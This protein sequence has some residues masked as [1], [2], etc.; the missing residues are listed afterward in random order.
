MTY[1]VVWQHEA[2]TE[3]RRLRQLD[4]AGAKDCAAAIRALADNPRPA[5]ARPLGG[6]GYWRLSSGDW[7]ILYR[8]DDD[9][10]TVLV[11]KTG[12]VL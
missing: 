3:F 10:V 1:T 8:P 12:R 5:Q 11:L 4:P 9:T 2:M 7:R 6:S